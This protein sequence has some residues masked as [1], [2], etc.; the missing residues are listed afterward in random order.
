MKQ[1][2]RSVTI[3]TWKVRDDY[4]PSNPVPHD[5]HPIGVHGF[6]EKVKES[7]TPA[8]DAY[9]YMLPIDPTISLHWGNAWIARHN[10]RFPS[11]HMK[12]VSEQEYYEFHATIIGASQTPVRGPEY[13]FRKENKFLSV[14]NTLL[15]KKTMSSL[16]H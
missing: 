4:T 3:P 1:N 11:D 2:R 6:Q 7:D 8:F 13:L 5:K 12:P 15:F 16:G 9:L 14:F 10:E